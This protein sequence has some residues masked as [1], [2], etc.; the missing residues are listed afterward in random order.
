M[1][2]YDANHNNAHASQSGKI[3]GSNVGR[4]EQSN[5]QS[6]EASPTNYQS[7]T[8]TNNPQVYVHNS[9]TNTY[10]EHIRYGS[11]NVHYTKKED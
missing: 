7:T 9:N 10:S 8:I 6:V 11:P 5:Y 3:S 2:N 4:N 1:S